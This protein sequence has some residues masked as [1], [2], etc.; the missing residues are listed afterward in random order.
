MALFVTF[1]SGKSTILPNDC[2]IRK[3][4]ILGNCDDGKVVN[5]VSP[6]KEGSVSFF[7][8]Y[9]LFRYMTVLII[10]LLDWKIAEGEKSVIKERVEKL[11]ELVN[12]KG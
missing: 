1:G 12:I 7:Q 9:A 2:W 3:H 4:L 8:N 10:L 6:I 5:D 11:M